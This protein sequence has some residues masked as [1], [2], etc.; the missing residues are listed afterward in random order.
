MRKWYIIGLA[1]IAIQQGFIQ[2]VN[3]YF[4]HV[5]GSIVQGV[6]THQYLFTIDSTLYWI[7]IAYI[8]LLLGYLIYR[9]TKSNKIETIVEPQSGSE[10][11]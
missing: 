7:T 9:D 4:N 2:A 3:Y 11:V 5:T 8:V 1:L 10:T 6:Y